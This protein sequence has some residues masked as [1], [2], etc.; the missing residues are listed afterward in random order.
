MF[1]KVNSIVSRADERFCEG[2]AADRN[3]G[4]RDR[5]H[6]GA[7]S[8]RGG[9]AL[10]AIDWG[11]LTARLGAARDLR[12]L[13]RRDA[14][15][16]IEA[17]DASFGD[18]AARYFAALEDGERPVNPDDLEARKASHGILGHTQGDAARG[19]ARDDR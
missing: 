4:P 11:E 14:Q 18:A 10:R 2:A 13:L 17:D 1:E 6:D 3:A 7:A 12:D 5:V 9:N 15:L 19:D 16:N 8:G